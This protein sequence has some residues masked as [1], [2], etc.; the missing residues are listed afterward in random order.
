MRRSGNALELLVAS[1]LDSPKYRM[2]C[3]DFVR[4]VGT[5][6]LA[7]WPGPR[8]AVK[9]TKNKLHQ[10]GGAYFEKQIDYDHWLDELKPAVTSGREELLGV[11]RQM[12]KLHASTRERLPDLEVFYALAFAGLPPIHSILDVACGLNPLAIPWM[13][14]VPNVEYYAVDI[15]RDMIEFVNSFLALVGVRGSAVT[16]DVLGDYPMR[17][18]DLALVL[19]TIPCL[20]QV[21]KTAGAK[22]LESI[23]AKYV[24]VSFPVY[25]LG[26]RGGKGMTEN[27]AERFYQLVAGRSWQVRKLEFPTELAFMVTK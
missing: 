15:Y 10:V 2:V 12:M 17:K 9:A 24:L 18:V 25:S 27:Y 13:P 26:G 22:L 14:V 19:K 4:R 16:G 21:D 23:Q 11:A 5:Q 8:Q 6:E 7:K 3:E 20:E 1:V